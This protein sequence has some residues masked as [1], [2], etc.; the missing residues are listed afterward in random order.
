MSAAAVPTSALGTSSGV[1]WQFHSVMRTALCFSRCWSA[2]IFL[3]VVSAKHLLDQFNADFECQFLT[4][5]RYTL[6]QDEGIHNCHL[7][8]E[9][10]DIFHRQ[11]SRGS[12]GA[13]APPL[14]KVGEGGWAPS[15]F[16]CIYFEYNF[17]KPQTTVRRP[18]KHSLGVK[19]SKF[20]F[21]E[22]A[23]RPHR[24]LMILIPE[25]WAPSLLQGILRPCIYNSWLT[26]SWLHS[27][28]WVG[29]SCPH[30]PWTSCT[31]ALLLDT[32]CQLWFQ[33]F[34]DKRCSLRN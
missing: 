21:Q 23:P 15:F 33:S 14:W 6:V 3:A 8:K 32:G 7:E 1:V 12:R 30:Q 22:H 13:Q 28:P 24:Q 31:A 19:N 26:S 17:K 27:T 34:A 18:Q 29:R 16:K 9:P 11:R 4:H 10:E 5:C 25:A 2:T 20:S